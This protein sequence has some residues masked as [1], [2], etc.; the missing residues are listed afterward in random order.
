MKS[1]TALMTALRTA[2]LL[3]AGLTL[4]GC[5]SLLA[6]LDLQTPPPRLAITP[7]APDADRL[8]ACFGKRLARYVDLAASD[9]PPVIVE[10]AGFFNRNPS[11]LQRVELPNDAT[12]LLESLLASV[13]P[14]LAFREGAR[15]EHAPAEGVA[16][17]PATLKVKAD[18][19]IIEASVRS[20][21]RFID[22]SAFFG[23][24]DG[25]LRGGDQASL[26]AITLV[27]SAFNERG[28][29]MPGYGDSLRVVFERS[30]TEERSI[31]ASFSSLALGLNQQ[32][33]LVNGYGHSLRLGAAIQL[34]TVLSR[35][36]R[37]GASACMRPLLGE[38]V[39]LSPLEFALGDFRRVMA[40]SAGAGAFWLNK[41]RALHGR[42]TSDPWRL[43]ANA[44][45]VDALLASASADSDAGR[46]IAQ[47]LVHDR[48]LSDAEKEFLVLW[49]T[50]PDVPPDTFT[51]GL[52]SID[53]VETKLASP[54]PVRGKGGRVHAKPRDAAAKT[55]QGE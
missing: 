6:P 40:K 21:N 27:M 23:G 2:L 17:P 11:T 50:L 33:R 52:R 28:V 12:T 13:G 39:D 29:G 35:A 24:W 46:L 19:Q 36:T 37:V 41:L 49:A 38:H 14:A 3:L 26:A 9:V 45:T 32:T 8:M 30:F 54:L 48:W 16:V 1:F 51:A 53:A 43:E 22:W 20:A 31:A 34:V 47:G 18:I 25:S 5:G 15:R 10:V 7:P 55:V 4:A 42:L 44:A